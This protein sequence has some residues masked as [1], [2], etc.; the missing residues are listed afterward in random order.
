MLEASAI[1]PDV[2]AARGYFTATRK[3]DLAR[4][5]FAPAQQLPPAL[6]V[7]IFNVHGELATYILRPDT[8]RIRQGKPAKYEFAQGTRM[9]LDVPR[10]DAN[11]QALKN[12]HLPLWV[13]EG[14]KK[15]DSL[16]SCGCCAVEVTGVWSWRGTNDQGGKTALADWEAIAL[17]DRTVY[18]V[19]DSDIMEKTPVYKALE[20]LGTFLGSRHAHV[21]Y[22]YLPSGPS[23]A[24]VG[25]DD[26]LAA[27]HTIDEVLALATSTLRKPPQTTE[28]SWES[29]L[30]LNERGDPKQTMVNVG[31]ILDHHPVWQTPEPRL[32]FDEAHGEYMLDTE[33]ISEED[34]TRVGEWLGRMTGMTVTNDK[35]VS[36]SLNVRCMAHRRDRLQEELAALPAWDGVERLT[37]WLADYAGVARTPYGMAVARL[38]PVSMLARAYAPGCQYRYVVVLCG[39][40]N[41]GKSKLLRYLAS[42]VWFVEL[43]CSLEGKEAHILLRGVWLAEFSELESLGR[44]GENRLK[45]Y[46]T[47]EQDA[48]V[49]KFS[50]RRVAV[51]RRTI[52][53]G[54]TNEDEFLKGQTGNTRYLPLQCHP[55]MDP[56]GFVRI[57]PQLLAEAKTYYLAHPDDWWHLG[58][59]AE[60]MA[61]RERDARREKSVYEDRLA[62]TVQ[63][64][65]D[66]TVQADGTVL[67]TT[68]VD[69]I[70]DTFDIPLA[71][72]TPAIFRQV[73]LALRALGWTHSA[74]RTTLLFKGKEVRVRPWRRAQTPD[75]S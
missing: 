70:L 19:F 67:Y 30:Q 44:T 26:Y 29:A 35:L 53:V 14:A 62:S 48:Y 24:K 23:G 16:I 2:I 17:N 60:A 11:R 43:S 32:W 58:E 75:D 40:E 47:M 56:E 69:R 10:L 15:A 63:A 27:G 12:P 22:V 65:A 68:W 5:G 57:R 13:T 59:D 20:R 3:V 21:R 31:L 8:P 18:L 61:V 51:P 46:I 64:Y 6:V 66:E 25:I 49:P 9:V 34:V 28:V 55:P 73:I 4:L 41:S 74:Q 7:P 36:R 1:N 45:S 50:N 52:F 38:L 71:Q 54:T 39:P 33:A 42:P 72:Q 37:H